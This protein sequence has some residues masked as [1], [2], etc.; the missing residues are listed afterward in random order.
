[1]NG[2][3]SA[4]VVGG[5]LAGLA[6]ATIL[7]ERG[8]GVVVL[9]REAVLGGRVAAFADRLA[10]GTPVEMERGFHAFFRHYY[11]LR[12]LLSRI[13]PAL[14]MLTPLDDYPLLGPMGARE[15][16]AGLPARPLQ[17]IIA[18]VR[19]T[20]TLRWGDLLRVDVGEA[21]RMLAFDEAHTY[22]QEDGRSAR[23]YLDALRFPA[24][25]RQMLFDVFAH[26]FFHAEE[27]L[28]AAELLAMFHFYFLGNPEGLVFDVVREPFSVA[29]WEPLRTRLEVGGARFRLGCRARRI[30]RRDNCW[31]VEVDG[32]PRF[33]EADAVVLAVTVPGLREI[34]ACSADVGDEAWRNAIARLS[35]A[36]PF[37]VW[38]LWLDRPVGADRAPFVGT[39]GFGRLDNISLYDRWQGESR[40]WAERTGGAVVELHAY[41]VS[42]DADERTLRSELSARL[43]EVYPETR[44]ARIVEE[45]FLLREDCPAF[46]PGS[47]VHRPGVA[48]PEAGLVLAGDFVRLPYPTALMERAVTSGMMAANRLLAGWGRPV[49]KIRSTPRRG[50][51]APLWRTGA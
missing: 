38:R 29:L 48:T 13:D 35:T 11:N 6:A 4:V 24:A 2:A 49:E 33:E 7:A 41:A 40:R 31:R 9:E 1:V 51:L 17:K 26:S 8:V 50:L 39:T 16:F 18:L 32:E 45:R 43:H 46:P 23:D 30:E 42:R 47:Y 34:V 44:A 14:G 15:S 37:A 20:P 3:P 36:R 10:D 28:S 25:A 19:R 22:A 5:G 12:A 27:E 21:L